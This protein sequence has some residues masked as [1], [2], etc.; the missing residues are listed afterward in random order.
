MQQP[1]KYSVSPWSLGVGLLT[2]ALGMLLIRHRMAALL[3]VSFGLLWLLGYRLLQWADWYEWLFGKPLTPE[4]ERELRV[5]AV[6]LWLI[7]LASL[8]VVLGPRLK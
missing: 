6:V 8:A 2:L 5:V 7:A 4:A 1:Y 3:C